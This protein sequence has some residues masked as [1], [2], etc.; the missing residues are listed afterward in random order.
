MHPKQGKPYFL[1]VVPQT[2]KKKKRGRLSGGVDECVGG[3]A[4][5]GVI[6]T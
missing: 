3:G 5:I 2:S 1:R 4:L 6:L